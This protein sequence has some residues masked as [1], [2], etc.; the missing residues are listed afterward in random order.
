MKN[1]LKQHD[2]IN[3]IGSFTLIELLVVIAII[4]ILAGMLLPALNKARERARASSCMNNMK[5]IAFASL[6]YTDENNGWFLTTTGLNNQVTEAI[7]D[8]H[9]AVWWT[10]IRMYLGHQLRAPMHKMFT[11]PSE[12]SDYFIDRN[13]RVPTYGPNAVLVGNKGEN[14]YFMHTT[15]AVHTPTLTPLYAELRRALKSRV[16]TAAVTAF[17]HNGTYCGADTD[18]N[19]IDTWNT[20]TGRTNIA[21]VDGHVGTAQ[22]KDI[23][24]IPNNGAS[25]NKDTNWLHYGM[26]RDKSKFYYQ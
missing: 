20:D 9:K 13:Y 2:K 5:Q 7:L 3:I 18:T 22:L 21:Y 15:S 8:D 24:A 11:C 1:N 10:W 14:W 26:N 6:Q 4:A 16:W 19:K 23:H 25:T 17:R 12:P